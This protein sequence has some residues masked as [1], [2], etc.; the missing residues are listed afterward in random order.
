M[1]NEVSNSQLYIYSKYIANNKRN[2]LLTYVKAFI[3]IY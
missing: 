1:K 2:N 3:L